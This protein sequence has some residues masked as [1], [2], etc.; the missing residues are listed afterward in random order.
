VSFSVATNATRMTEEMVE[1]LGKVRARVQV[2]IDGRADVHDRYRGKGTFEKVQAA[3]RRLMQT[4]GI[5]LKTSTVVTPENVQDLHRSLSFVWSLNA[6]NLTLHYDLTAHWQEEHFDELKRQYVRLIPDTLAYH[7][8]HGR[9]PHSQFELE[10]ETIFPFKCDV[11]RNLMVLKPDGLLY[12]CNY[13]SP[14]WRTR[15][16]TDPPPLA[17][18][19]LDEILAHGLE[20]DFV[21]ERFRAVNESPYQAPLE[22]RH[23][24]SRRCVECPYL[25]RCGACHASAYSYGKDPLWVP[26]S[27]CRVTELNYRYALLLDELLNDPGRSRDLASRFLRDPMEFGRAIRMPDAVLPVVEIPASCGDTCQGCRTN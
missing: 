21:T 10:P 17:L 27:R 3:I 11:G 26:E 6:V 9:F 19:S 14:E 20:S 4:E 24:D 8:R 1:I 23:T 13:H 22:M 18:G 7:E 5:Q 2:S 25:F 16:E 12:G 15:T